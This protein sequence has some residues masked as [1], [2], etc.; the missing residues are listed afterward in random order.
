MYIPS[1]TFQAF[2]S[3]LNIDQCQNLIVEAHSYT[4]R[5]CLAKALLSGDGPSEN[6]EPPGN[7]PRC[8]CGKRRAMPLPE[9]NVCC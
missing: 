3:L 8:M 6:P 9:E 1:L 7:L 2:I 5:P 4:G